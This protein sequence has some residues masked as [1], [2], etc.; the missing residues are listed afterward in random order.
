MLNPSIFVFLLLIGADKVQQMEIEGSSNAAAPK[1]VEFKG[2]RFDLNEL[3]P[4][5]EDE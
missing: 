5:D 4:S 2:F 3:P 1:P